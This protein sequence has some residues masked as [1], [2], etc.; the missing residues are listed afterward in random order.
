MDAIGEERVKEERVQDRK[1]ERRE[2]E[3]EREGV[4]SPK[5]GTEQRTE[6]EAKETEGEKRRFFFPSWRTR[7]TILPSRRDG[8]SR[9]EERGWARDGIDRCVFSSLPC[10]PPLSYFILVLEMPLCID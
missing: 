1:R 10:L 8:P 3:R 2:R 4:L 9:V 5:L 7:R 6:T